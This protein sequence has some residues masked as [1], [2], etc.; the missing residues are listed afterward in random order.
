MK[1]YCIFFVRYEYIPQFSTVYRLGENAKRFY[2]ILDGSVAVLKTKE[3]A[4]GYDNVISEN[5]PK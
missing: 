2:I 5:E 1:L 3:R 4:V